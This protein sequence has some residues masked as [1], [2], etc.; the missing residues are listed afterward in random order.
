MRITLRPHPQRALE[1]APLPCGWE[2][3][4]GLVPIRLLLHRH[5]RHVLDGGLRLSD[6]GLFPLAGLPLLR[7]LHH[8][9]GNAH[10]KA[11]DATAAIGVAAAAAAIPVQ[12]EPLR[13]GI[14]VAQQVF[15]H[16][17][18]LVLG[19]DGYLPLLALR[20]LPFLPRSLGAIQVRKQGGERG[21]RAVQALQERRAGPPLLGLRCLYSSS[22]RLRWSSRR[23]NQQRL[24]RRLD[25]ASNLADGVPVEVRPQP[26]HTQ[27]L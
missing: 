7:R 16:H 5:P 15:A 3:Q 10:E 22:H 17:Q 12:Q 26:K 23:P 9:G 18:G 2:R 24:R 6:G 27:G 19:H 21:A 25:D 14:Q 11:T 1:G 8:R 4:E 13:M 20:L